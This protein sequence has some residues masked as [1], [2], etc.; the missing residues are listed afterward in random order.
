MSCTRIIH[1]LAVLL[2][3]SVGSV[4]V[5]FEQ[6]DIQIH[7]FVSQGYMKSSH[8]NYRGN[9]KDGSYE[10]NEI[11]INFA[12][13]FTGTLRF[14]IQLFSRDIGNIGNNELIVDWAFMDYTLK[15]WL[16]FRIGKMK[17]PY[18]LYNRQRDA[19]ML[20][21]FVIL[22]QS[23]YPESERDRIVG[24]QG[25][26][27]YGSY[28]LG[29]AGDLDYEMFTGT[30]DVESPFE[31]MEVNVS[32]VTGGMLA[33]NTP[34]PGLMFN[35]TY[36]YADGD[37]FLH[38]VLPDTTEVDLPGDFKINEMSVLS[39]EYE[40][41]KVIWAGEF[42]NMNGDVRIQ[43]SSSPT[44]MDGWYVSVSW[45]LLEWM[46]LGTFHGRY[47]DKKFR[48]GLGS[49]GVPDDDYYEYQKDTAGCVRFN[50][51]PLWCI[52]LEAHAMEGV[53]QCDELVP[54]MEKNW[55]LF[56][57]KTSLNF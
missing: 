51:T 52:K 49:V 41:G 19:D 5:A 14:G 11:G 34:F 13:P 53:R 29:G 43:G 20:R 39:V 57:I 24:L 1:I 26:S 55:T 42:L 7:G 16:G 22:P 56:V 37:L 23:V 4:A 30:N 36:L 45:R 28:S 9:T 33:W 3:L 50:V 35:G 12:I 54:N 32:H 15:N 44:R 27:V 25:V 48:V 40:M 38:T 31:F 6:K 8:N 10:F 47:N 21:T 2:I 18:G 46:E 17:M